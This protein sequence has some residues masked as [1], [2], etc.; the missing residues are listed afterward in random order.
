VVQALLILATEEAEHSSHAPFYILGL[1]LAGLAVAVAAVGIA[2]KET[3]PPTEGAK[4]AVMG[5]TA[6]LVI[7]VRA[8]AVLTA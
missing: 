7:A 6:L 5:V 4:R 2:R 8:S 3:F 1:V